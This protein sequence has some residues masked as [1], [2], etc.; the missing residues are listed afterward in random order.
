MKKTFSLS[1]ST[2]MVISLLIIAGAI[3]IKA[4]VYAASDSNPAT[5]YKGKTIKIVIP[6]SPG[7]SFDLLS[8][9]TA[10]NLPKYTGARV[11]VQNMPGGGGIIAYN[12]MYKAKPN[13]LTFAITHG[14]KMITSDLFALEG[15]RY[16]SSRFTILGNMFDSNN[17]V[18]VAKKASWNFPKDVA[19][20]AGNFL[21]AATKPFYEPQWAEAFGWNNIKVIPGY[22]G[23]G[24]KV[25]AI[26]RGEVHA[27]VGAITG[28]VAHKDTVKLLA[29][30][31]KSKTNPEVKTIREA[32]LPGREKW[33]DYMEMWPEVM[34][35]FIAAPNTPPQRAKFLTEALRKVHSDRKF[36]KDAEKIGAEVRTQFATPDNVK[37]SVAKVTGLS[38][39]EIEELKY[40]VEEKY[41]PK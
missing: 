33:L 4:P 28:Y 37:R 5:Y 15:V 41:V 11:I 23:F 6:Y 30:I 20:H 32:A 40:V 34:R 22:G 31:F 35:M 38:K 26:A 17:M 19:A 29:L 25:A 1:V 24:E 14:P 2:V 27:A 7:G 13:G 39:K 12:H 16:K 21:I 9:I 8:R 10:T 3:S 36:L 18:V